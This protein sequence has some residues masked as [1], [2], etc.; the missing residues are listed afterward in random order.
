MMRSLCSL[1]KHVAVLHVLAGQLI[2]GR[3]EAERNPGNG[4]RSE[5]GANY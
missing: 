1:S 5:M 3:G 2:L 4:S